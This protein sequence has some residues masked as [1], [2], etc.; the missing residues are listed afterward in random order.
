MYLFIYL[1][2]LFI[3]LCVTPM[4][5]IVYTFLFYQEIGNNLCVSNWIDCMKVRIAG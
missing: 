1:F 4:V 2:I 3:Y 5:D